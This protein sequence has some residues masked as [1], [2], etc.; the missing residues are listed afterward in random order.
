MKYTDPSGHCPWCVIAAGGALVGAGLQIYS[1]YQNGMSGSAAW[2]SGVGTAALEGAVAGL[3]V[4]MAA[5]VA[6][7]VAGEGLMGVGLATGSTTLFGAGISAGEAASG[8]SAAIFGASALA[9]EE[10]IVAESPPSSPYRTPYDPQNPGRPDPAK[11]VDTTQFSSGK[12]TANGGIRNAP[13]FWKTWQQQ[14]PQTISP[15]NAQSILDGK[16]P[17]I[18][19]QW[20]ESYPEHVGFEGN[21][22]VHH[23]VNQGPYAIPVPKDTHVGFGGPWHAQ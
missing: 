17:V 19:A 20:I 15:A 11:S 1:N 7:A 21:G 10:G 4:A 23:H 6:L 2:T 14:S 12:P 22:L 13:Q 18:D 16:S 9:A 3:T 8:L 5:P